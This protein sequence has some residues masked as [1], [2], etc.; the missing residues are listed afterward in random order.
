MC[1]YPE[2]VVPAPVRDL[3]AGDLPSVVLSEVPVQVVGVHVRLGS[4]EPHAAQTALVS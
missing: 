2:S 4:G 3:L 1:S